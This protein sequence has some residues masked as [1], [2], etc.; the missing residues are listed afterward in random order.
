M[1]AITWGG[2]GT[3]LVE[4]GSRLMGIDG[5]GSGGIGRAADVDEVDAERLIVSGLS[6]VRLVGVELAL[7]PGAMLAGDGSIGGVACDLGANIPTVDPAG[8]FCSASAAA[9]AIE[10]LHLTISL[11]ISP[12]RWVRTEYVIFRPWMNASIIQLQETST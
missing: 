9:V 12:S 7:F 5:P 11:S 2:I 1:A 6:P 8:G 4:L 3:P 10:L